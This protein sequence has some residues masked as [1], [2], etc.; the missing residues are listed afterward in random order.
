M[1]D[2]IHTNETPRGLL[3]FLGKIA[4]PKGFFGPGF[5]A[6]FKEGWDQKKASQD[7]VSPDIAS[8]MFQ[9]EEKMREQIFCDP[10]PSDY[11]Y[12]ELIFPRLTYP[13]NIVDW[14]DND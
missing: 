13:R 11:N 12:P 7:S 8:S 2:Q 6:D 1:T 4:G 9:E 14:D 10:M 3:G 5:W